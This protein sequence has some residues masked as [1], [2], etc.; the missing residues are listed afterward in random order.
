MSMSLKKIKREKDTKGGR[1]MIKRQKGTN[2]TKE[3]R[4]TDNEGD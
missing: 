3:G 2:K 4:K 1:R